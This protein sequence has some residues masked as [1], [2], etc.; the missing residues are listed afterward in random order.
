MFTVGFACSTTEAGFV[1]VFG[2]GG[3]EE[4]G[5][6]GFPRALAS[7]PPLSLPLALPAESKHLCVSP[8][9]MSSRP[10]D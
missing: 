8:A 9:M 2:D 5:G 7:L 6:G 4:G 10:S 3:D 1:V